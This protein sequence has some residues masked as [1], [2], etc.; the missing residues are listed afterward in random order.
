MSRLIG[1]LIIPN[2]NITQIP[3]FYRQENNGYHP[4]LLQKAC[5]IYGVNPYDEY[6]SLINFGCII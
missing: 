2:E 5:K 6:N 3:L 4:I 1:V